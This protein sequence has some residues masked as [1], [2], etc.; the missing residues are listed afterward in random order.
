MKKINKISKKE[1]TAEL[2]N[3]G[4][5]LIYNPMEKAVV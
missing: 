4:I 1:L 2:H 3:L 5:N